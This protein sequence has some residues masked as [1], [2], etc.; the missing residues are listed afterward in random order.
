VD[1]VIVVVAVAFISPFLFTLVAS[2]RTGT[3]IA[4]DPLGW[5]RQF[6]LENYR[7][8][9]GLVRFQDAVGELTGH[10]VAVYQRID[11]AGQKQPLDHGMLERW[12][13]EFEWGW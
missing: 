4:R 6:T 8:I 1:I 7:M 11:Q 13:I 12:S 3:D 10:P 2:F 5:P 9:L